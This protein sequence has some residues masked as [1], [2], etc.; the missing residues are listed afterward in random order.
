MPELYL[1]VFNY[2]QSDAVDTPSICNVLLHGT[3]FTEREG[4]LP[5]SQKPAA[6]TCH[7]PDE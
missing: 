2:L 3:P 4:S 6:G 7:D 1:Q 5:C